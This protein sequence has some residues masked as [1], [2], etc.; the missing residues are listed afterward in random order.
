MNEA[1]DGNGKS[2]CRNGSPIRTSQDRSPSR[3]PIPQIYDNV[4]DADNVTSPGTKS[5]VHIFKRD[6]HLRPVD[7]VQSVAPHA[8]SME[9]ASLPSVVGHTALS[10]HELIDDARGTY[11]RWTN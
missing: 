9:F 11:R 10:E 3:S 7:A 5:D 8:Q 1:E 6:I 4:E 2:N